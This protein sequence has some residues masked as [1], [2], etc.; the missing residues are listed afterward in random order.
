MSNLIVLPVEIN[1]V[2][3]TFLLDTGVNKPILFNLT[4]NDSLQINNVRKI[5]IRGLGSGA[6]VEA[7]LSKNNTM[8]IGGVVSTD[9]EMYVVLDENLN[10]STR[11]GIPIHGIIGHDLLKD[12][13]VELK[14]STKRLKFYDPDNYQYKNCKK[15]ETFPLN[16]NG[17]KPYLDAMVTVDDNEEIPVKLLI[18]SGGSDAVWLFENVEKGIRVP[19]R[20]FRD[21]L[22]RGLGGSIYGERSRLQTFK[23]GSFEL[24][25]A[26]VAFPDS[27]DIELAYAYQERNGS[28]GGDILK[29]FDLVLDY[30]NQQLT[31]KKNGLFKKPFEYNMSGIELQHNGT[32]MVKK[33]DA[34]Y[35][36]VKRKDDSSIEIVLSDIYKMALVPAFEIAEVREGSPA[37]ASGLKKGDILVSINGKGVDSYELQ[38][39]IG[40]LSNRDG[41]N[42]RLIVERNGK[43]LR[44]DFKLRKLL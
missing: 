27:L 44:F 4:E 32:R 12:F 9:Q 7:L 30:P 41:K 35:G 6:P 2:E 8:K 29:R 22:G 18:D 3:L 38:E 26:K 36:G 39:V 28:I 37:E 17:K 20:N 40:M 34:Q 19:E 23:V 24:K 43:E 5:M 1:G 16:F 10:F 15:C 14:Y 11:L 13:I 31:L 42:I 21:F 33:L 25:D